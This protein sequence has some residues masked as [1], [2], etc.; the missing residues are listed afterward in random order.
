MRQIIIQDRINIP[1]DF[2]FRYV[3]WV[4]VP[5]SRQSFY[6]N[7]SATSAVKDASS[8]EL[9]AIQNGQVLEKQD[10]GMYVA[11]TSISSIQADLISKWNTYQAYINSANPWQYYGSSWDGSVWTVNTTT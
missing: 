10:I 1:S 5:S 11:G 7:P 6:A 4:T 2:S 3:F 8:A 9:L